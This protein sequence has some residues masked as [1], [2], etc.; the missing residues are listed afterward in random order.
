VDQKNI[1]NEKILKG[2]IGTETG[3]A[4]NYKIKNDHLEEF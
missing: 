1:N 4:G 2:R 3:I